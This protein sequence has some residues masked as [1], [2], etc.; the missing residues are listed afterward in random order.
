[1]VDDKESDTSVDESEPPTDETDGW[2]PNDDLKEPIYEKY[3]PD[4]EED[5]E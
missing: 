3:E 5:N 2:E 4:S 1:M